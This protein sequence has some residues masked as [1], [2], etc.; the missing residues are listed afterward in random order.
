MG[1]RHSTALCG[2]G[3]QS[4]FF[5]PW[6]MCTDLSR[7]TVTRTKESSAKTW[8][9]K[10]GAAVA[11]KSGVWW[12]NLMWAC[13]DIKLPFCL[14]IL[15]TNVG[16]CCFPCFNCVLKETLPKHSSNFTYWFLH[17]LL[18]Y[19]QDIVNFVFF[20]INVFIHLTGTI[21]YNN[22]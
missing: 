22:H 17:V 14:V 13:F 2:V 10:K 21:K 9:F 19:L 7:P 11:A 5:Y 6:G 8:N 20:F 4:A 12:L 16:L 15:P 1:Y 18:S 3:Q